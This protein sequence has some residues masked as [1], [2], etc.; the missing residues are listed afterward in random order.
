MEE[1]SRS[2]A[3]FVT[4]VLANGRVAVRKEIRGGIGHGSLLP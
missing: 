1:S 3:N 2:R 4:R